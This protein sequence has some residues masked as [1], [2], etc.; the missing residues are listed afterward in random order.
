MSTKFYW[1]VSNQ[2]QKTI[3]LWATSKQ[4]KKLWAETW[5]ILILMF[6]AVGEGTLGKA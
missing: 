3:K 2:V 1:H 5:L 6:E 4:D